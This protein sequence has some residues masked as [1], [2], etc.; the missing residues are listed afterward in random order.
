QRILCVLKSFVYPRANNSHELDFV[1]TPSPKIDRVWWTKAALVTA[2]A[3]ASIL[4][5][6]AVSLRTTALLTPK[7]NSLLQ[8]AVLAERRPGVAGQ[9]THRVITLEE[10]RPGESS[11]I[12]SYK[13]ETWEDDYNN[14]RTDRIYDGNSQ[15]LCER[16][17][18]SNGTQR[19]Y[20][21][22][23]AD[24]RLAHGLLSVEEFW[25]LQLTAQAF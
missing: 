1:E 5:F 19:F 25:Q 24:R 20:N 9:V 11:L 16:L 15:L 12:T 21:H 23:Q 22:P 14:R 18:S 6:V 2:F 13:V 8:Q 17:Q 4:L 10:R 7:P 3:L